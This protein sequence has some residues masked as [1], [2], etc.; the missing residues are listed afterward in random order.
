MSIFDATSSPYYPLAYQSA[1]TYGVPVDLFTSIISAESMWD[2]G[3]TNQKSGAMGLGQVLPST[4]ANPGYGISPLTNAYDPTSNLNFSAQYLAALYGQYGSWQG[5]V[6]AYSGT[7]QG[8][9]P[10]QGNS[11]QSAVLAA[12]A[13]AGASPVVPAGVAPAQTTAAS[14]GSG[15]ALP[16]ALT[17]A[18]NSVV[19]SVT[20]WL[21]N[22]A[23]RAALVIVA[24]ILLLGAMLAFSRTQSPSA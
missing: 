13:N 7:P 4:A 9:I 5:A 1:Q 24:L 6:N 3:I 22:L 23:S 18:G 20:S 15:G 11:Q 14:G 19:G 10:Y 17:S 21:G 12:L 2:A 8:G 16:A